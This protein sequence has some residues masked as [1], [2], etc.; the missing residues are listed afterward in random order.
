[1]YD[2]LQTYCEQRHAAGFRVIVLTVLP[3]HRTDTF[4]VTRL[5][6][7]AML[8]DGW[9]DFADDLVDLAADPRIGDTGTSTTRSS[10]WPTSCTSPRP[11]TP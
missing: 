2:S 8:R 9:S 5:A 1:M 6:F 10:I 11:A 3:C 7:N 4:E